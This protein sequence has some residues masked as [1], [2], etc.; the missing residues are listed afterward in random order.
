M[1]MKLARRQ[2]LR[3]GL[4]TGAGAV[5]LGVC[6]P[7]LITLSVPAFAHITVTSASSQQEDQD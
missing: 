6:T 3:A 2:L 5:L 4:V 7:T 1:Q